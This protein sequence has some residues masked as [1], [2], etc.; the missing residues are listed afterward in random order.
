VTEIFA[1]QLPDLETRELAYDELMVDGAINGGLLQVQV[2]HFNGP[3]VEIGGYG[4]LDLATRQLDMIFSVAP[5][6]TVDRIIKKLPVIGT[7]L[8][9]NLL[10]IPVRAQGHI[11]DPKVTPLDPTAVGE[12]LL[13]MMER[14]FQMPVQWLTPETNNNHSVS[15]PDR[16]PANRPDRT[17]GSNAQ[18]IN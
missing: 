2:V 10:A 16:Q 13:K 15:G 1:G 4:S 7:I 12:N 5:M 17:N 14:T 18:D 8:G 3:S 9:G 11:N 6:K